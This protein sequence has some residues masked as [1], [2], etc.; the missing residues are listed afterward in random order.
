VV[1][2]G[3]VT[4]HVKSVIRKESMHAE[5]SHWRA[6]ISRITLR[7]P[8]LS[9]SACEIGV[10]AGKRLQIGGECTNPGVLIT[11]RRK[12]KSGIP[13][14][15]RFRASNRDRQIVARRE[16]VMARALARE[17]WE[18][19]V[20]GTDG[21]RLPG[22]SES[23]SGGHDLPP[24]ADE[25]KDESS[26]S[27]GTSPEDIQMSQRRTVAVAT[28]PV[29]KPDPTQLLKV[30]Y[31]RA[32]ETDLG[33]V[34]A[35]VQRGMILSEEYREFISPE[36]IKARIAAIPDTAVVQRVGEASSRIE[37]V[38]TE[39]EPSTKD[40]RRA[41]WLARRREAIGDDVGSSYVAKKPTGLP[42]PNDA[43]RHFLDLY[44]KES[45]VNRKHMR[46]SP[47]KP[48][49]VEDYITKGYK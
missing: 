37:E 40:A 16:K 26:S 15:E 38:S 12:R 18:E 3:L 43:Q 7:I 45:K 25:S 23:T 9:E 33:Q 14:L 2:I 42:E 21:H 28:V 29:L 19:P 30:E 46:G 47:L 32:S 11:R 34:G 35:A 4:R 44:W 10:T 5:G 49:G 6:P 48:A 22:T 39:P 36:K 1:L 8:G 41:E 27:K 24:A 20:E 31:V 13:V 17:Q